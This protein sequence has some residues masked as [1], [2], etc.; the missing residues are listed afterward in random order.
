M[1]S[2]A[3]YIRV[4]TDQQ[5][6]ANQLPAILAY[7]RAQGWPEPVIYSENESAWKAGHQKELGR[8]LNDLSSGKRKFEYLIVFALDRLSRQGP[9][10]VLEMINTFKAYGVKVI[11]I[12]EPFTNLPYGFGDVLYAFLAWAAKVES[13]RKST[14]TRA[15][16]ARTLAAGKTKAGK[17]FLKMGRPAGSKD[18]TPRKRAGYNVRW[19]NKGSKNI[20]NEKIGILTG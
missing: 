6:T 20:T 11:S 7:C 8:L 12:Q 4:S 9:Y 5:T 15:G 13:E 1:I 17:P 14:N 16:L 3:A 19:V 18:K 2:T 10:H